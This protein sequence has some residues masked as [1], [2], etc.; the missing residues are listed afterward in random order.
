MSDVK[1]FIMLLVLLMLSTLGGTYLA[2]L[3]GIADPTLPMVGAVPLLSAVVMFLLY[4]FYFK[5]EV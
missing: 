5:R 4:K 2:D 1:T 3:T